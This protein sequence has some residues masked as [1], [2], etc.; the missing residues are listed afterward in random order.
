M[1]SS[2]QSLA[3]R[4][5]HNRYYNKTEFLNAHSLFARLKCLF[6]TEC[7]SSG[8]AEREGDSREPDTGH[9]LS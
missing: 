1:R 4:L 7:M 2:L 9:D 6:S 3:H 8:G 5:A